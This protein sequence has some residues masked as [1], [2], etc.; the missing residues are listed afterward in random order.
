MRREVDH[1][2]AVDDHRRRQGGRVV[3]HHEVAGP[4][5]GGQVVKDAMSDPI[6]VSHHETNLVASNA[7]ALGRSGCLQLE[8]ED[9]SVED[10]GRSQCRRWSH[11]LVSLASRSSAW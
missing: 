11:G 3:D 9:E 10:V 4:Q 1:E 8:W 7:T 5:L 6:A 2:V